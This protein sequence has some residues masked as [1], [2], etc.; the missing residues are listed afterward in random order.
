MTTDYGLAQPDL[1]V[2]AAGLSAAHI[3]M[4]EDEAEHLV[5]RHWG[6]SGHA[7]RLATE[8]DDTFAAHA[9]DHRAYILKVTNPAEDPLEVDLEIQLMRHVARA[10]SSVRVPQLFDALDGRLLIAWQDAAGQSRRARLMSFIADTPLDSTGSSPA[11]R[12]AVGRTLGGLRHLTSTFSHP[13]QHRVLAW[14]VQHLP[15]L[16]PLA[17]T[18]ADPEHRD[19]LQAGLARF[20]SIAGIVPAL[21]RQVLHNDFS[22]SNIIVDHAAARFVQGIIDFGDAVHTAVAIDVATALLNQLPRQIPQDPDADLFADGRDLLRGY[23]SVADLTDTE[24]ATI[25]YL[26]LGRVIARAL[27]TSYRAA[28]LP[29]NAAYVLRNTAPGW[30]QLRWFRDQ[31]DDR[32]TALLSTNAGHASR[33]GRQQHDHAQPERNLS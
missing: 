15:R 3:P 18:I 31:P 30:G 7:T 19:L 21:R 12:E 8:K 14:D 10:G 4:N 26:V 6:L 22:K 2:S 11:E 23:L 16:R 33:P 17:E 24:L 20:D 1:L 32:L 9:D 13:A 27:I 5:A 25:P 28:L 29:A